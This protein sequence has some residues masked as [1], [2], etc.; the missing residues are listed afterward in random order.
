MISGRSIVVWGGCARCAQTP[1][2]SR[3]LGLSPRDNVRQHVRESFGPI[4]SAIKEQ[5]IGGMAAGP[6]PINNDNGRDQQVK[7][8]QDG[9]KALEMP[10]VWTVPTV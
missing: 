5:T 9:H 10:E 7:P 6:Q 8:H 1:L 2:K 4:L 3:S